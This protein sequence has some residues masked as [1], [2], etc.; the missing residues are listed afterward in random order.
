MPA[1]LDLSL[2]NEVATDFLKFKFLCTAEKITIVKSQIN[3]K[4][5]ISKTQTV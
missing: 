4:K 3:H 1:M 2:K 5:A